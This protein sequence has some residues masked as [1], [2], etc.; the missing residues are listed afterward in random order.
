MALAKRFERL[1]WTNWTSSRRE[2]R[3]AM[4]TASRPRARGGSKR[5]SGR[6]ERFRNKCPQLTLRTRPGRALIGSLRYHQEEPTLRV[7]HCCLGRGNHSGWGYRSGPCPAHGIP[8]EAAECLKVLS[9]LGNV[10]DRQ[11][12]LL[13]Q[14]FDFIAG[15]PL[16]R[17]TIAFQPSCCRTNWRASTPPTPTAS[18]SRRTTS[19]ACDHRGVEAWHPAGEGGVAF[20]C[21]PNTMRA[22]DIALD[23]TAVAD[24]VPTAI[25]GT[26]RAAT[27]PTPPP[28]VPKAG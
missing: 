14:P 16:A 20:G 21:N 5:C 6:A 15:G 7:C 25:A 2:S 18:G 17:R 9:D 22:H 26:M 4:R 10:Q 28:E 3:A 11:H 23:E 27:V 24:E 8:E 12:R 1:S 19:A 13:E